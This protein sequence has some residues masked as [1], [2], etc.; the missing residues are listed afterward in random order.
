[1]IIYAWIFRYNIN[2]GYQ[3][4][5]FNI[6]FTSIFH[7]IMFIPTENSIIC[8]TFL[9]VCLHREKN[10]ISELLYGEPHNNLSKNDLFQSSL[11]VCIIRPELISIYVNKVAQCLPHTKILQYKLTIF[12]RYIG[13]NWYFHESAVHIEYMNTFLSISIYILFIRENIMNVSL[14]R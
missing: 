6:L 1:M 7:L 14:W 2:H 12:D 13:N 8:H 10:A 3:I 9:R 4:V 5:S 11:Q